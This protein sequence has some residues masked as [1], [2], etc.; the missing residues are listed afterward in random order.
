MAKFRVERVWKTTAK[1][2]D[3]AIKQTKNWQHTAIRITKLPDHG[4]QILNK[5][6]IPADLTIPGPTCIFSNWEEVIGWQ[7]YLEE[8]CKVDTTNLTIRYV[9]TRPDNTAILGE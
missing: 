4:Y 1:N 2:I 7:K 8:V 9:D 5:D 6:N 3:E